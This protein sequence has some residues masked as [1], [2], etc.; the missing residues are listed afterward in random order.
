MAGQ[1]WNTLGYPDEISLCMHDLPV[2]P[3]EPL[4]LNSTFNATVERDV[5]LEIYRMTDGPNWRNSSGW[6]GSG[7]YC[8]WY[9]VGC[10]NITNG[11][12]TVL[13]L[14]SN[15]LQGTL[16]PTLWMLRD[17]QGLCLGANRGLS[18]RLEVNK[19]VAKERESHPNKPRL[20]IN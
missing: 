20:Q 10:R 16:P 15:A 11:R 19:K 3:K 1:S 18:G 17:L 13:T 4:I 14:K 2:A 5:L 7:S 12:V 6:G 9:G 8:Q